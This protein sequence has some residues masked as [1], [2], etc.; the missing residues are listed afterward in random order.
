[1]N[2]SD[3]PVLHQNKTFTNVI[4]A[5]KKLLNREF[6][7]C[8]FINCDFTKSDLSNNDFESCTFKQCNFSLAIIENTGFRNASFIGCKIL[9]LDFTKCNKFLFSFAFSDCH[10]DYCTFFGTKLKKT[11]FLN[12][13]M[14]EVEFSE[15]DLSLAVFKNCDL[16]GARFQNTNLEKADFRTAQNFAIDPD[17]NKIKRAKFSVMNLEGLLLRYNLDISYE[18]DA[19]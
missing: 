15:S 16:T 19:E 18:D 7:K 4:Y 3:E 12:C 9:G 5:G 11:N 10:L 2:H 1:M 14:K 6:E 13:S 8:E 17:V